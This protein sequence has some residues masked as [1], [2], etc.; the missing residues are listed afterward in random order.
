MKTLI[1]VPAR[2]G[3]S[4]LPGKPLADIAGR[5]MVSRVALRAAAAANR[6]EDAAI[7]VATDNER[8]ARHCDDENLPWVMTDPALASGSDRALAAAE[9]MGDPEYI[10]NLQGDA[11]FTPVDY[12]TA[13]A[14]VLHAGEADAATP[15]I[16][17]SWSALDAL[18]ASK[19]TS[20]FSGTTCIVD[21]HGRARWFSKTII[22]A[23][24][25]EASLRK[26]SPHS[27]VR[28]HVGLYGFR[29]PAL[30]RF[31]ALAPSPH[32]I[33]EGLEQLRLL[34]NDMTIQCVDV[35]PPA[36]SA[37]GVDTQEDLA[38]INAL[39]AEHGDPD[40]EL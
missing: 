18:R 21:D 37:T 27:P 25:D 19:R 36:F 6:I 5:S 28:R 13:I 23:I 11:P 39:V 31:T 20:P 17:L 9:Q 7:V 15:C 33:L 35:T 30:R 32:E 8:I 40:A 38:R 12:L 4:R 10:L 3:S 22:P 24:R 14:S 29:A 16:Q 2:Y 34:E 1:V 26:R